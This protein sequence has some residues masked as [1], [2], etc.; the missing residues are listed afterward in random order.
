MNKI[1]FLNTLTTGMNSQRS[2]IYAIGGIICE[3]SASGLKEMERITL[4]IRPFQGARI[5]DNSLWIGGITR[6][7][8]LGYMPEEEAVAELTE[9][10]NRHVTVQ[11]PRDKIYLAGFNVTSLDMPFL[12]ELMDRCGNPH[13]RDYFYVQSLDMMSFAALALMGERQGMPD[14]HLE[15]AAEY[16]GVDLSEESSDEKYNCLRNACACMKIYANLKKR[17]SIGTDKIERT[18]E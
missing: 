18:E 13:F 12:K 17:F 3:D 5:F 9:F 10:L 4:H 8:L 1:L 15:T 14:F 2:G 6:K 16:L 7:D 11:N